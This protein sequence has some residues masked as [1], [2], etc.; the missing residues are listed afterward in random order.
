[1]APGHPFTA[2]FGFCGD[3]EVNL[4]IDF[5]SKLKRAD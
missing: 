3:R 2:D 5:I 1:M 4:K